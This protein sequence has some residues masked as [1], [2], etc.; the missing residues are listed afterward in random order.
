MRDD[1][2]RELIE[3]ASESRK[4]EFG[5]QFQEVAGDILEEKKREYNST[6]ALEDGLARITM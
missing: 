2:V 4:Y 5:E 3:K 6:S 1:I